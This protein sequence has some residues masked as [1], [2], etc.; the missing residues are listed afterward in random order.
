MQSLKKLFSW[1]GL[2]ALF[3][4]A[5][6]FQ[7]I[8]P[9]IAFAAE[10]NDTLQGLAELLGVLI[11]VLTF[12]SLLM[13][14]FFGE[15]MGTDLLTGPEAMQA[16]TPMWA[17]VRNLTN[18]LFV[19]V[20]VGLAFSNLFASFSS[21]GGGNWTIKEKLPKVIIALVAINFSLLGFKLVIDAVNVGT[22]AI[23]GIADSRLDANNPDQ[24]NAMIND[25]TWTIVS[26]TVYGNLKDNI[27][28]FDAD[29]DKIGGG[30][31]CTSEHSIA[32]PNFAD[33]KTMLGFSKKAGK[34]KKE[35]YYICRSFRSLVNDL[36]C[37]GWEKDY[38]K[39]D[40]DGKVISYPG[41]GELDDDCLFLL[42]KDT[43]KTMLSPKDEPG[44][45]LFMSFGTTFMHLERLPALG[46]QINS[47][48]GV[49]MNTLFS[50]ILG[51]AYIVALVAIF[52]ALIVRVIIIWMALVFSPI[53]IA[54]SIMG[55]GEGDDITKRLVS[56]VIMPLKIAASFAI[57]FVMMSGMIEFNTVGQNDAFLFG[58]ALSN[59]G[60]AEYGFM[61]QI[62]TIVVFW[63]A[64]QWALDGNEASFITEKIFTG[65]Q[66][67]GEFAAATA[68][69]NRQVFSVGTGA[70]GK[71]FSM[72]NLMG[73]KS[74][75]EEAERAHNMEGRRA[76]LEQFGIGSNEFQKAI[77]AK[78]YSASGKDAGKDYIGSIANLANS[79]AEY[80]G[81]K[82][83]I[84]KSLR[85]SM[86][87]SPFA[88][89]FIDFHE[90]NKDYSMSELSKEFAKSTKGQLYFNP[91]DA[92]K[93]TSGA[94]YIGKST[95]TT[96]EEEENK[97]G[98][99]VF[100]D[101]N[102]VGTVTTQ[103]DSGNKQE[104]TDT[105]IVAAVAGKYNG[106][107]MSME[108][109]IYLSKSDSWKG[110]I[111]KAFDD[112]VSSGFE[113]TG[114]VKSFTANSN[115]KGGILSGA[116]KEGAQF[117]KIIDNKN[118]FVKL[119]N[120]DGKITKGEIKNNLTTTINNA[121]YSDRTEKTTD[122]GIAARKELE[123][124]NQNIDIVLKELKITDTTKIAELKTLANSKI[125]A[126]EK[127]P[128]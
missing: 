112:I 27:V 80:D 68:T 85:A 107:K 114:G 25:K 41:Q 88:K 57:S 111:K 2:L 6:S 18:I 43:F 60:V 20:L 127:P 126:D 110:N 30:D 89:A 100:V 7:I 13:M 116:S 58:P 84:L 81:E 24:E 70:N 40:S 11:S 97:D 51:L 115:N 29:T 106:E 93:F 67:L 1:K 48:N 99:T 15:L 19:L 109:V 102:D 23:L 74:G 113:I 45:N 32:K 83:A 118:K 53:L 124:I 10:E 62:A 69:V 73:L 47:L 3:L 87:S 82:T 55:L 108:D 44:Q 31:S 63:K 12:I 38:E 35:R 9:E 96:P 39:L 14:N 8:S 66:S 52:I 101:K 119:G 34:D 121:Y 5:I 77:N 92:V 46:A 22:V 28:P 91:G 95:S 61:W 59:L 4:L 117:V 71:K 75:L 98:T 26:K 103:S 64:A 65:A 123:A 42:K 78:T 49:I 125:G 36:F 50:S 56:A 105:Q 79:K 94:H 21:E 86:G 16:I 122:A 17:W 76:M 33:G 37:S 54:A 128:A 120:S 90:Q 104:I 72:T